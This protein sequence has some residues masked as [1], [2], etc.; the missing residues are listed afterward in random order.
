MNTSELVRAL[1]QG[2]LD[3]IDHVSELCDRIERMEDKI[4]ALVAGSYDRGRVIGDARKLLIKYPDPDSRPPLFGLGLGVKD[5]FHVPGFPTRCGSQLP[6]EFLEG[7]TSTCFAQLAE[8]GCI[9]IAKTVTTEF[10][11]F[12]PGPTRNPHD[13]THSPGG[14]SSGSAAGVA[15]GFFPLALGTQTAGSISRPAAYCG[16]VGFKPSYEMIS[17]QG[18]FPF[19][20]SADHVG[21]LALDVAGVRL[22]IG[23]VAGS[24]GDKTPDNPTPVDLRVLTFGIPEGPYLKQASANGQ[25]NFE[26]ILARL[27]GAGLS[28]RRLPAFEDIEQI[29]SWHRDLIAGEMARVHEPLL[30]RFRHLYKARTLEFIETGRRVS[31]G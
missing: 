25:H 3:L 9:L 11:C 16:I 18:V 10:A 14:S 19:S 8:A 6:P 26:N 15:C 22:A 27:V 31:D 17:R 2:D 4:L 21:I 1:R 28:V 5:I 23:A 30:S 7:S 13:L 29:N 12:E 24:K 20:P